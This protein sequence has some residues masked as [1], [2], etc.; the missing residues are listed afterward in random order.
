MNSTPAIKK[1]AKVYDI[2]SHPA[3]EVDLVR[4]G[5][6]P[7]LFGQH[8][9]R[10]QLFTI[11]GGSSA[12]LLLTLPGLGKDVA[13][14]TQSRYQ[15]EARAKTFVQRPV[16]AVIAEPRVGN[17]CNVSVTKHCGDPADHGHG[18]VEFG[19]KFDSDPVL[20]LVDLL[21]VRFQMIEAPAQRQTSPAPLY[22]LQQADGHNVLGPGL[23]GLVL[24]G[25]MVEGLGARENLAPRFWVYEVVQG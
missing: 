20:R 8:R 1:S 22:D 4:T 19:L 5:K 11:L 21:D 23:F 14:G 9:C 17:H 7:E 6:R 15:A 3:V 12:H 13:V 25:G 2:G 24:L 16:K 18:L 10:A